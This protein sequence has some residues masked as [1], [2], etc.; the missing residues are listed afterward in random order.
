MRGKV[1]WFSVSKG[2][3]FITLK[4]DDGFQDY[5]FHISDVVGPDAP[6]PGD[7]VSFEYK[8]AKRGDAAINI[9]IIET[10][11]ST[12]ANRQTSREP[13]HSRDD[14]VEC[15]SCGKKMVPRLQFKDG[16]PYA[17]IC[18]FCMESQEPKPG[19]FI[20]TAAFDSSEHPVVI[21]LRSF[22][23]DVLVR[24]MFGRFFIRTYYKISPSIAVLLE[25]FPHL[26]KPIR[27]LLARFASWL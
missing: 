16:E 26:K 22:R 27:L 15:V 13:R 17:R 24:S 21:R 1:K 20:A 7:S 18:P 19:C 25:R 5:F 14:R 12:R 23:D 6:G 3:G 8:K 10:A 9:K 11:N 2:Y 4:R